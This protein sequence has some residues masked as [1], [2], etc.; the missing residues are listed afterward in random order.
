L[1]QRGYALLIID[2]AHW[3]RASGWEALRVLWSALRIGLILIVQAPYLA[4]RQRSGQGYLAL[5]ISAVLHMLPL[6]LPQIEQELLPQ[7]ELLA[8]LAGQERGDDEQVA[9]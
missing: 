4:R 5:P 1:E 3:L 9:H 8:W 6:T 2:E 7:C